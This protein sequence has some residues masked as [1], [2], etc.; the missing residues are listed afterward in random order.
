MTTLRIISEDVVTIEL[1]GL[2]AV[3]I[4]IFRR[5]IAIDGISGSADGEPLGPWAVHDLRDGIFGDF[6]RL[7]P[8]HQCGHAE[9]A[10]TGQHD[11]LPPQIVEG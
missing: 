4:D 5:V 8:A 3:R 10:D 7:R 11:V 9:C 1:P 6:H 2:I